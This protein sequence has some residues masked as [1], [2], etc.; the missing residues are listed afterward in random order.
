MEE[1]LLRGGNKELIRSRQCA[2]VRHA[3]TA[4][5]ASLNQQLDAERRSEA[6]SAVLVPSPAAA[7]AAALGALF[8][9]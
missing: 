9:G 6:G 3:H 1:F 7:P 8:P 5:S 4:T 2:R